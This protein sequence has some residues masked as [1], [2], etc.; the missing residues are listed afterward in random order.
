MNDTKQ[1]NQPNKPKEHLFS[2]HTGQCIYCGK[3]AQDDAIEKTECSF[4]QPPLCQ[5]CKGN[6]WF[7][8]NTGNDQS[9]RYEIQQCDVCEQYPGD[10]A[11][12]EAVEKTAEAHPA[13]LKFVEKIAGLKHEGEPDDDG[14][15]ERT[16]RGLHRHPQPAHPGS[17]ARNSSESRSTRLP[18]VDILAAWRL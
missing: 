1:P 16:L 18:L 8:F 6:G 7:F 9:P 10:L 14:P 12:L 11:A 13:L 5:S 2:P 4:D 17:S 3:S 15:F